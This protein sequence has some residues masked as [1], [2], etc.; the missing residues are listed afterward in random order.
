MASVWG[1]G[2][3]HD[4]DLVITHFKR[5]LK[6]H[7]VPMNVYN[8]HVSI[9]TCDKTFLYEKAH[10]GV[11]S[12]PPERVAV[13]WTGMSPQVLLSWMHGP[14]RSRAGLSGVAGPLGLGPPQ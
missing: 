9:K 13:A 1:D 14:A 5:E 2:S 3:A 12:L 7:T 6:Y 10:E 8:D 11:F 4:P